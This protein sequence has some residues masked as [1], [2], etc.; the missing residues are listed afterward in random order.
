TARRSYAP[1]ATV[2]VLKG[3]LYGGAVT[4]AIVVQV[5]P[6]AGAR[7]KATD[8]TPLVSSAA[9]T[10]SDTVARSGE[11]GSASATV[12]ARL[13]TVTVA[14]AALVELPAASRAIA[15]IT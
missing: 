2:V 7:W 12:G 9:V 15:P 11:P 1:S 6:P 14:V 3:A 8:A 5:V 13:S 10:L 4:V